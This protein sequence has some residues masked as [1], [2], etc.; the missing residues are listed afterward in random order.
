[1]GV[2]ASTEDISGRWA[3]YD[4]DEHE[5][6]ATRLIGDAEALLLDR[7]PGVPQRIANGVVSDRTVTAV[8]V[9]MVKRVLRNPD[10]YRSEGDG[11]YNYV[12]SPGAYTPGEV[13]MTRTDL[14]RLNGPRRGVTGSL[15]ADDQIVVTRRPGGPLVQDRG[16]GPTA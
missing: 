7:I 10:G 3:G 11:D 2:Y 1:M 15:A 6:R 4:P 9:D 14:S 13:G 8:V 12:Y 16:D 5:D